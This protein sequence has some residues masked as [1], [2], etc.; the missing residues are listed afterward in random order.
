M[1]GI[2]F[3]NAIVNY[4]RYCLAGALQTSYDSILEIED[5]F[6][7]LSRAMYSQH[8]LLVLV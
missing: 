1:C 2:F 5:A 8:E 3:N 4:K 7:I 6:K